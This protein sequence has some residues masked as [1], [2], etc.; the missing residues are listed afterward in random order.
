MAYV[1]FRRVLLTPFFVLIILTSMCY[2]EDKSVFMGILIKENDAMIPTFLT[3][4]AALEYDKNSIKMHVLVL[5][6]NPDIQNRIQQWCD[7]LKD[8][9]ASVSYEFSAL[10]PSEVKSSFLLESKESDFLFIVSS[11]VF[12]KPFALKALVKKDLPVVAPF[13]RPLPK[14]NDAHRNFIL[15]ATPSGYNQDH[16]DHIEVSDRSKIGTFP[17]DCVHGAYLIKT[18]NNDKLSFKDGLQPDF[19]AFSNVARNMGVPQYI[20]NERE[21]GFFTHHGQ[22][23]DLLLPCIQ[24]HV[25]RDKIKEIAYRHLDGDLEKYLDS[26]PIEL[27]ALYPVKEDLYWVDEKFDWI[28][29]YYIK[30]GLPWEPHIEAKLKEY[31]KPGATVLD[32]GGHIGTHTISLSRCV[33]PKGAVHVFEPQAKLFAE[34]LVNTYL[35]N[36]ENV[37]PHRV[38]LGMEEKKA[39]I[40]HPCATNEG[41]A[42]IGAGGESVSMKTIDSFNLNNISLVKIDI[43]GYE[44]EALKGG[45][46]TI[47]RN[48]PVMIIE[49]FRNSDCEKK[50]NYIRSLGYEISL[51]EDNDYLC[52]PVKPS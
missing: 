42:T 22:Q 36:C 25:S 44:I 43:E 29:S 12:L 52:L 31:A 19:I 8:K 6:E 50:L 45:L 33:G 9:Y 26:F 14:Q 41:M 20:C 30:K 39:E 40:F 3:S 5:N 11:D 2:G 21:F 7:A 37:Y 35:N 48:K 34:L 18:C 24:K 17:A 15:S 1:N 49:V 47:L 23:K 46:K 38:A 10:N 51:L 16:P 27:Y 32:I 13:L 4:I 28:K